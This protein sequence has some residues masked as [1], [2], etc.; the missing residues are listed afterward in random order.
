MTLNSYKLIH[1]FYFVKCLGLAVFQSIFSYVSFSIQFCFIILTLFMSNISH[2]FL[3]DFNRY[4]VS[5]FCTSS[6]C[7]LLKF[8][9]SFMVL[10]EINISLQE[11]LNCLSFDL[12][13]VQT[14]K[15]TKWS[16]LP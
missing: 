11:A 15:I 7:C 13:K 6:H 5:I 9:Y 10:K 14:C 4:S 2:I 3:F 16:E 8:I 1:I 12:H